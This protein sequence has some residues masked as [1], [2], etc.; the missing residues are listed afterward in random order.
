M[1]KKAGLFLSA[2]IIIVAI[3][4]GFTIGLKYNGSNDKDYL[5]QIEEE[6][7]RLKEKVSQLESQDA[8]LK[9]CPDEW[10]NNQQPIIRE[11]ISST[12]RTLRQYFIVNKERKEL[13]EFDM[14]WIVQNCDLKIT[15][16]Y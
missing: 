14:N 6:N 2:V 4:I 5:N 7:I 8:K 1:N 10:I 9:I 16:V 15:T 13:I 12:N 3:T 11:N